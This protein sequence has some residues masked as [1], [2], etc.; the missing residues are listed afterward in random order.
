M[1]N[2]PSGSGKSNLFKHL[3]LTRNYRGIFT[4][5]YVFCP[6][7]FND[8]TLKD[9]IKYEEVEYPADP[10][11]PECEETILVEQVADGSSLRE[12]DV[13]TESDRDLLL[14]IFA[15]KWRKCMADYARDPM[16]KSLFVL[17]D[18]SIELR[19]STAI[20]NYF[21]KGRKGGISMMMMSNHY[22]TYEPTIRSQCTH[23]ALFKPTTELELNS[24]I[25]DHFGH[26]DKKQ[27]AKL[28]RKAFR[29]HGDFVYIDKTAPEAERFRLRFGEVLETLA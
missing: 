19:G 11:D 15:K 29:E 18:L 1:L 27:A 9:L 14:E 12:E 26:M 24:I 5:I 6:T 28:F 25:E 23:Y 17:D 21:T 22:R 2:G 4:N 3:P 8:A 16:C 10:D 7:F 13:I 20:K